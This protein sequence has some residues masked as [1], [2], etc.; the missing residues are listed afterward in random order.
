MTNIGISGLY[1]ETPHTL[2]LGEIIS[3]TLDMIDEGRV[4]DV[5]GKVVHCG[6]GKGMGIKFKDQDNHDIH[7][8]GLT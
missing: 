1:I 6:P 2:E 4:I 8:K 3:M 7:E 5:E